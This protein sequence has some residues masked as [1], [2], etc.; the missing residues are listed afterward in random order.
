MTVLP[1]SNLSDAQLVD[2][3]KRLLRAERKE[4]AEIVIHLADIE[5]RKIH[6]AA[7]CPS[8]HAY[9]V[10]ELQL[11]DHEAFNRIEAARAGRAYPRIFTMLADGSLTLTA[12]QLVARKLTPE[13]HDQLLLAV[14]G[15]TKKEVLEVLARYFPQPDVA[16]RVRKLPS[17]HVAVRTEA[18]S[19]PTGEQASPAATID[20]AP[21]WATPPPAP[22]AAA[23]PASHRAAV[24]PLAPDRYKVTFTADS[25]TCELLELAKDMLSHAVPSRETAEVVKRALETLVSELARRKFAITDRR[26]RSDGPHDDQDVSAAVKCEV[27]V[28]DGGR[29]RFVGV[30]GRRC[31]SRRFIQFHHLVSRAD[32]GRGTASNIELRC[33][34]HNRYEADL[35]TG[36]VQRRLA[37]DAVTRAG[38]SE[39]PRCPRAEE[40]GRPRIGGA[41]RS[42]AEPTVMPLSP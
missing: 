3:T 18:A 2:A 16:A 4:T 31:G 8:L 37:E 34:S 15:R 36:A 7:G 30:T 19:A 27:W 24:T 35:E 39:L 33:G 12:A 42:A 6:L 40:T 23:P 5:V 14:S 38:T 22:C 29:C 20:P 13:N 1:T 32:G 28:R 25:H 10:E 9:C 41:A 17:P 11:D 26:R 21:A